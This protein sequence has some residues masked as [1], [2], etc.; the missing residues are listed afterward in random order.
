M[1]DLSVS[2][3]CGKE[4]S[5]SSLQYPHWNVVVTL[6]ASS[7]SSLSKCPNV[8]VDGEAQFAPPSNGLPPPMITRPHQLPLG[9]VT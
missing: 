8:Y 2:G 1:K 6:R 5:D 9:G 4:E 3:Q 7:A